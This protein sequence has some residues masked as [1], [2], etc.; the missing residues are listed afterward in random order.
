MARIFREK[1]GIKQIL[2]SQRLK[3]PYLNALGL[4]TGKV[5]VGEKFEDE[6]IRE[7]I[8]ETGLVPTKFEMVGVARWID[9]DSKKTL[10]HDATFIIFDV[11]E[12]DGVL[13]EQ[14]DESKN[15]WVDYSELK[16]MD[17]LLPTLK[18]MA[19]GKELQSRTM[20]FEERVAVLDNF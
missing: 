1:K 7:C 17:N 19:K 12:T 3:H 13:I 4:V 2:V 11:Y 10:L 18:E 15:F 8:E 6:M 5:K 9:Y 20:V 14:S 16:N